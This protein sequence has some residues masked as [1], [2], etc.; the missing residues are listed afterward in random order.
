MNH[1]NKNSGKTMSLFSV[2]ILPNN[3][4]YD[5]VGRRITEWKI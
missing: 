4:R 2:P 5:N 3:R 1:R